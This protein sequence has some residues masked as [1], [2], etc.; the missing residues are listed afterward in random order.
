DQYYFCP[1]HPE[2]G[3]GAY[4]KECPDRKPNPGMLLRAAGEFDLDLAQ[5]IF[6]GDRCSDMTAGRAAKVG[7]LVLVEGIEKE[8]CTQSADLLRVKNLLAVVGLLHR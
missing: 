4:R 3:V 8:P 7:T 6:V 5:C 2:H 1:H